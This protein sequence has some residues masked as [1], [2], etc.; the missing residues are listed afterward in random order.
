MERSDGQK[1]KAFLQVVFKGLEG[2]MC[3]AKKDPAT[4]KMEQKFFEYPSEITLAVR[5][6]TDNRIDQDIYFTPHLLNATKRKKEHAFFVTT[7]WADLD[8][9]SPDNCT[10]KP[11]MAFQTS[12]GRFQAYWLFSEEQY[13]ADIEKINKKIAYAHSESGADIS[14]WDLTQLLRVPLTYN[15]K[16]RETPKVQAVISDPSTIFDLED[17]DIYPDVEDSST[18]DEDIVGHV[19]QGVEADDILDKYKHRLNPRVYRLYHEEP[20]EDWSRHLWELQLSLFESDLEPYEVYVVVDNAACNKY[21]RDKRDKYLRRDITRAYKAFTQKNEVVPANFTSG[22]G[23]EPLL[24]DDEREFAKNEKCITKEY[25]E[26]AKSLGDAPLQYHQAGIFIVLSTLLTGAVRLPTSFGTILPN[27]WFMIL[28]DTTLTR[29]STAMDIATDLLLDVDPDALLATDGSIEGMLSSLSTRP[30]RPSLFLR[31]EFTGMME[32]VLKKDYLSGMLETLT[33]LYDGKMQKRVLKRETIEV[34]EPILTL[35]AGGI[36][37]K[38]HEILA[39]EHVTSGFLPRFC[40][41]TAETDMTRMRPVGPP[42]AKSVGT[43]DKLIKRMDSMY[44]HY[45]SVVGNKYDEGKVKFGKSWN[46]ELTDD[47]WRRYNMF[48][49]QMVDD[50]LT[51]NQHELYTPVFSR[52][53]ISGLKAAVLIAAANRLEDNVVVTEQDLIKAFA[54]VEMWR[55]HSLNVIGNVG[56]T[57][58]ERQIERTLGYIRRK[59]GISRSELMRN[60]KLM[61][62]DADNILATLEQ[63][64]IVNR[65]SQK[66]YPIMET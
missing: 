30:G 50:A 52:L 26:W 35:F 3:L 9:C 57:V 25:I 18:T 10:I 19:P 43:R 27:L 51:S 5:W 22:G 34:R 64:G 6:I 48:E 31:D 7:A 49:Q 54:Y 62:R 37:S 42:T 46:A 65:K 1:I 66:F 2:H 59:P 28:A 53:A 4:G 36:K 63:R 24:T 23:L 11:S 44:E 47:A 61:A 56:M 14:G 29:K 58:A 17:F 16:Y 41:I 33:K 55:E 13:A 15:H 21:K 60:M 45:W 38:M 12:A 39:T 20:I 40:F 32:Q 8:E